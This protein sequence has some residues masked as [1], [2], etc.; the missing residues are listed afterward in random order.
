MTIHKSTKVILS[1]IALTLSL[2]ATGCSSAPEVETISTPNN[3]PTGVST[4]PSKLTD[5]PDANPNATDYRLYNFVE[6]TDP[7]GIKFI[8]D[9]NSQYPE[10]AGF[11]DSHEKIKPG[12]LLCAEISMQNRRLSHTMTHE[13]IKHFVSIR[14]EPYL[15]TRVATDE[16][17]DGIAHLAIQDICPEY[18]NLLK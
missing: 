3:M 8:S 15:D 7:R 2:S 6:E 11:K 10:L 5:G 18:S 17:A 12:R 1:L 14:T 13:E 16:E 9:L 4:A